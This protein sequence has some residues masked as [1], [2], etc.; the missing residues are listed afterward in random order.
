MSVHLHVRSSYTLLNST[1][2]I[3]DI[4]KQAKQKGYSS[5]ALTDYKVMHGAMAFAHACHRAQIKPIFGLEIDVVEETERLNFILWAKNDLGFQN[6]MTLS[7][8]L[9]TTMDSLSLVEASKYMDHCI[10]STGGDSDTLEEYMIQNNDEKIMECLLKIKTHIPNCYIGIARNDAGLIKQKNIVLKKHAKQIGLPTVAI[11]RCYYGDEVDE[12]SYKT[13]C[14]IQQAVTIDSQNLDYKRYRYIRNKQEMESLYDAEDLLATKTIANLCDVKLQFSKAELPVFQNKAGVSSKEYLYGLCQKGLEKRIGLKKIPD[15]YKKR[16]AYELNMIASMHYED[17]F[18]IVWDFIRFAKTKNIYIG[19]GRGS[20]A[21]SLVAYCLGITHVDPITY[22]LL[23]ERFLN[24]E[25]ISMPD[26]DTDF[27]DHRRD[28]VIEYVKERYGIN[29]VA[30]IITFHTLGAKQALR[31]VGRVYAVPIYEIDA[32]CKLVPRVIKIDLKT[33]YKTEQR[34]RD[35]INNNK[36]LQEVFKIAC[37]IE[38]LP[39]H[40]SLH[41]AGIVLSD[42]NI[43][44]V[45][46]LT[47]VEGGFSTT[48]YTM[49]YMEELG[50]IK[51]D[52][53]G[54]RNLTIIDEVVQNI[55][56]YEQSTFDIMNIPLDDIKSYQLLQNVDTMGVFQL[57]SEGIKALIRNMQPKI[58]ED[59]VATIA[60][61][62]P[63]PMEN[64]PEYLKRRKDPK[65]IEYPD[66][67]LEYILKNTYGIM[68]YQEQ[69]MQVVQ[70]MAGF[71]LGKADILRKAISKKIEKEILQLK[72]EFIEGSLA[73]GSTKKQADYVYEMIMKFANYGF[74]RSH[75][76]AYGMVAYQMA[77]LKANYPSYFFKAL[78]NSVIGAETKTSEYIFEAKKHH[79]EVLL[80]SINMS[81][82]IYTMEAGK[83]RFPLVGIKN[84]G[85]MVCKQILDERDKAGLF[86]DLFDFVA[87]V[88]VR[89]INYKT[90][91]SLIYAGALDCFGF[92]RTSMIA[93]LDSAFRYADIVKI[94]DTNQITLDFNLVEKPRIVEAFD[95][96]QEI[97]QK[98]YENLG[99]YLTTHP[100]AKLRGEQS[101]ELAS[102]AQLQNHQGYTK[103]ICR[104]DRT[105]QHR[106]KHGDL[107]LF[108]VASDENSKIDL[109]I[110]PNI[111]KAHQD[112]LV[113]GNIVYVEGNIEQPNSCLVKKMKIIQKNS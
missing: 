21:G 100:I 87:R 93:T 109:V 16:L 10:V 97:T 108:V 39:R 29:H 35:K 110:M 38:G 37:A 41:A 33:A 79:I 4:V 25:R 1:L 69:I 86:K 84:V 32:L 91:E 107:M 54:L 62:R 60:L 40:A 49:E 88:S 73:N 8:L 5:I 13:L 64:I 74:N 56:E 31:D 28:E 104:I 68:I 59:I 55:K 75:S 23:F 7:S 80:P 78:L 45:C 98:E 15:V 36:Q 30:H 2:K 65:L 11:S 95:R 102:L 111:Y 57:E 105:R 92:T 48:Q 50:L 9:N 6:L 94:E 85:V 24:P 82:N 66:P 89:K 71:S 63:G 58:F 27:P 26:I 44:E 106:T 52:F 61:F 53:L 99:F 90:V 76:V 20:A 12:E 83:L 42:R 67:K 51:M 101:E 47:Y 103:F 81:T 113:K 46:P 96:E 70:V 19:P 112:D 43:Y 3:E 17:Y 72:Q 22:Q 18:L 34:F 14:A 77:Y